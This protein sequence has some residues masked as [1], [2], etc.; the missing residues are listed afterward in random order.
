MRL[1]RAYL[2]TSTATLNDHE[3]K[4]E[5]EDD[6]YADD[7]KDFQLVFSRETTKAVSRIAWQRT[8]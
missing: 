2:A 4:D 8:Y 6:W 5:K 3:Y 1:A 7:A